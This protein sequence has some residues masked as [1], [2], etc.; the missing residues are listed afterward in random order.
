MMNTYLSSF[1]EY[2]FSDEPDT[3]NHT[4]KGMYF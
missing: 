3:K 4:L 2:A 1:L